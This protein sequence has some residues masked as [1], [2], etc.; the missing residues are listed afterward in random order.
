LFEVG[1]PTELCDKFWNQ[2]TSFVY[3]NLLSLIVQNV[4]VSN[5]FIEQNLFMF[6]LSKS[7]LGPHFVE[8]K[9]LQNK[10][11]II[12]FMSKL[13]NVIED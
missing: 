12:L 1:K 8:M 11:G 6:L 2:I 5:L 4:I 9:I 13:A 7:R 10:N 3:L